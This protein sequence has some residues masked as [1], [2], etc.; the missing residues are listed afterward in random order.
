MRIPDPIRCITFVMMAA[1]IATAPAA[2]QRGCDE[3]S[4]MPAPEGG[5]QVPL[6][7]RV[8][9]KL[10]DVSL[11]DALDRVT[12]LSGV[13]LAYSSDL[14]QLDQRVCV[15]AD[16]EPVGSILTR[17]LRTSPVHVQVVA[18][19]VVLAPAV[20]RTAPAETA[21]GVSV[22]ERVV[23]TGNAVPSPRRP[24]TMGVEVIDGET[25]RRQALGSMAEL[26]DAAVPGV[27][28]WSQSPSTMVA[29][30]GGIRGASSFSS[31]A[32][33]IYV[34]GI[35]VA[36][37]LI[38]TQVNPDVIDRVE[39]IRGPQ[40]SALYGS[41]AISGVVNIITRH[42][43]GALASPSIQFR[44]VAG[45]ANSD[46]ASSLVPTHEERLNVRLGTNI[47]SAGLAVAFGQTGAL[48][49]S[50]ESR[51]LTA[52][53][54]GR[55]VASRMTLSGSAR[56]FDKRAGIGQN[57]TLPLQLAQQGPG[58]SAPPGPSSSTNQQVLQE[59][60]LSTNAA[61]ATE[62]AWTHT[63]LAGVDGYRLNHLG[64]SAGPFPIA[65]DSA[66]RAARGNADRYTVRASSV[67]HLGNDGQSDGTLTLGIE[68]S[69]LRQ[70]STVTS[71]ENAPGQHYPMAVDNLVETWNHNT[72]LLSQLN[73]AWRNSVFFA[74]GL[75][76][77]RNDSFT[78]S[79]R[80]P[81]LPMAGVAVVR[82]IGEAELKWRAAYGKGIRP[83]LTPARGVASGYAGGLQNSQLNNVLPALD[84]EVQ[85]GFEGGMELY[86]GRTLTLQLTRFDQLATGLIQ[87]VA[88]GV[89]TFSRGALTERRVRYQYQNVGEIS[90]TG[91]EIQGNA[92]QGAFSLASSLSSVDSRVRAT[93]LGYNGDLR[94]GDRMLA[95]PARTGSAT[96]SYLGDSW[97]ASLGANRA[98][99][100]VNYDRVA[101]TE[102]YISSSGPPMRDQSG[103]Y[104]RS[105]WKKYDGDTHVRITASRDLSRGVALLFIGDNLLGG[106]LGEPDNV[107]IRPGRTITGGV[108]ASF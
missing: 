15:T 11:R 41:D 97:F 73:M 42:D 98:W 4:E 56:L 102:S 89:D 80:Y 96:L 46:Y 63:I 57:P 67:A 90:N 84:P 50:S 16:R 87:N 25:L 103:A 14:L 20:L 52:S 59:Y 35:E 66:L 48:Y 62:G 83:P 107:T 92:T 101:L 79:N 33:K 12:A 74:G 71:R 31:S 24:L 93:A 99:D 30:Y 18:G 61:V 39:V 44:S 38:V 69:V 45:A 81:L 72:G 19:R 60:T 64:D 58:P 95:V 34:D 22:L 104:L 54:D 28:S 43:G 9:L 32:P 8:S 75:R 91:W 94:T 100:W 86:L 85:S 27:W 105:Y 29:Q 23:V 68:Q 70:A 106:Q 49:P 26:L 53:T 17:L 21:R 108:R 88:I 7:H 2:A 51:Q 47:K 77:E 5:W 82:G 55:L 13:Q 10:R 37:P 76:L 65:I 3:R 6:E 40:G 36:N 78:G 1:V